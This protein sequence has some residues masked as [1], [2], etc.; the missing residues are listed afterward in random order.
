MSI[1]ETKETLRLFY[2]YNIHNEILSALSESRKAKEKQKESGMRQQRSERG[3]GSN[4]RGDED[5]SVPSHEEQF[6][7]SFR[8]LQDFLHRF[9]VRLH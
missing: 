5:N 8:L 2:L 6:H 3:L 9:Q 1:D 4:R 7:S